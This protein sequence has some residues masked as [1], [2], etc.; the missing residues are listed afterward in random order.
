MVS[1]K[2]RSI[3]QLTITGFLSVTGLLFIALLITSR[4]LDGLVERNVMV[5]DESAA[6]LNLSHT[7]VE[8]TTSLERNARQFRVL[9][10]EDILGLYEERQQVFAATASE[11]SQLPLNATTTELIADLQTLEAQASDGIRTMPAEQIEQAYSELLLVANELVEEITA[12]SNAQVNEISEE[13]QDTQQLLTLQ[14]FLLVGGALLLAAIFTALITRPLLQIEKAIGKLGSGSYQDS[15]RIGGPKDLVQLGARLDWLRD[16]L[17]MLEQQRSS[18]LRHVS[19]ELKTPLAAIRES[20]SL[21]QDEVLGELSTQQEEVLA[22][23]I[24]NTERLQNLIDQL[25]RHHLDSFSVINSMPEAVALDSLIDKV[26]AAHE[27]QIR[28]AALEMVKNLQHITIMTNREQ[29]RVAIDNLLSNAIK[30]SPRGGNI[31]IDLYAEGNNTVLELRDEG[32]GIPTDQVEHVFEAF[33]QGT[34]PE[35]DLYMGSGLGLAIARE[36]VQ[37]N[38][39]SIDVIPAASGARFRIVLG[40]EGDQS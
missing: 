14:A 37:M 20:A 22:I 38:G 25:L 2:P 31:Y 19:H 7:L 18:F 32:P 40:S 17:S 4:Q 6:A 13:T 24:K 21:L 28:T 10:D 26:I 12:W 16:R 15:I 8:L 30:Y 36:Y 35:S 23:Q 5:L 3:L 9:E 27:V 11:L 34:P 29:L 1:I 39:G 33:Y